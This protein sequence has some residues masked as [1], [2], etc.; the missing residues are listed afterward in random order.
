MGQAQPKDPL[1]ECIKR[2]A[3][4]YASDVVAT[5]PY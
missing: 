1:K 3:S 5:S 2:G 4:S